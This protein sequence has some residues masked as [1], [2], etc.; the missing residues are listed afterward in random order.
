MKSLVTACALSIL[1][2]PGISCHNKDSYAPWEDLTPA[3]PGD[4]Q[5]ENFID[6]AFLI[7]EDCS[8]DS[9]F[10]DFALFGTK[11]GHG[12]GANG[13]VSYS[14]LNVTNFCGSYSVID[15]AGNVLSGGH[16]TFSG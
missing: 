9:S 12:G 5:P 4:T 3:P 14:Y 2:L 6:S 8:V 7:I 13:N 10:I 15:S 11:F 16:T 1:L